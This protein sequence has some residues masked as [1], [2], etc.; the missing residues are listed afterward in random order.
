[1]TKFAYG[2]VVRVME[3]APAEMRPSAKA[4]VVGVFEADQRRGRHFDQFAPGS[5]YSVEFEDGSSIDVH[6]SN[7]EPAEPG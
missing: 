3:S 1:M 2:D 4:W 6:E 5:V 7:L